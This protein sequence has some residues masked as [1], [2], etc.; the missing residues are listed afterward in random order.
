MRFTP[1]NIPSLARQVARELMAQ[2]NDK[3]DPPFVPIKPDEVP[4]VW[5]REAFGFRHGF[6]LAIC[7]FCGKTHHYLT[8]QSGQV[9][10]SECGIGKYKLRVKR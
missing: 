10:E 9:I 3:P 6:V 2:A 5:V 1:V 7:P 8:V 4:D